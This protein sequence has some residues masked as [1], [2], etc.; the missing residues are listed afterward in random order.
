MLNAVGTLNN[1]IYTYMYIYIYIYTYTLSYIHTHTHTQ[2][3]RFK[4]IRYTWTL[5]KTFVIGIAEAN[6]TVHR[7]L[8][9]NS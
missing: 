6:V 3:N 7:L 9:Y 1:I 8:A 2:A 4:I 5:L